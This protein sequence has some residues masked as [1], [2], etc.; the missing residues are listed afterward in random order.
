[1][2]G[3]RAVT[4]ILETLG[5]FKLMLREL[6]HLALQ[7]VRYLLLGLTQSLEGLVLFTCMLMTLE[8]VAL[9]THLKQE[10]PVQESD[11]EL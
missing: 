4:G 11:V 1:M 3:L 9:K 10:V 2:V 8:M 7:T 5:I 6:L